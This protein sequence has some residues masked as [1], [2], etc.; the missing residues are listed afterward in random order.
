MINPYLALNICQ[1]FVMVLL[2][3][4]LKIIPWLLYEFI[5]YGVGHKIMTG[6][7]KIQLMLDIKLLSI[8][9]QSKSWHNEHLSI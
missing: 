8:F 4:I 2:I 5:K 1:L 9:D 7:F 3:F 6:K